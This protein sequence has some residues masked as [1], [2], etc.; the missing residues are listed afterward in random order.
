L[1]AGQ[2][3]GEK[4]V[5]SETPHERAFTAQAKTALTVLELALK[6][7]EFVRSHAPELMNDIL[8]R[9]FQIAAERLD[10]ANHLN[11]ILYSSDN[12][13]RLVQFLLHQAAYVGTQTPKGTEIP[14][15]FTELCYHFDIEESEVLEHLAFLQKISLVQRQSEGSYLLLDLKRLASVGRMLPR[16]VKPVRVANG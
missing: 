13:E 3:L 15:I 14:L 2:F 1:E 11:F 7:I 5:L 9:M 16:N 8:K 4:M 6:D 10:K 12:R